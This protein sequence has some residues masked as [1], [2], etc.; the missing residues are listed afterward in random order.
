M[1]LLGRYV[2]ALPEHARD[3]IIEA[4]FWG[5]GTLVDAQG[6]RCLLGHAENWQYAGSLFRN[7]AADAELQ[8][9]RVSSFGPSSHLEIGRRFDTLCHRSGVAR[10][11]RLVKMRAAGSRVPA[12][13]TPQ[14]R[15][16]TRV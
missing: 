8:R 10:A 5:M 11:V 15:V 16:A 1:G 3:R 13:A 4:Q 14:P 9:W 12:E 6:N 2:D 7:R